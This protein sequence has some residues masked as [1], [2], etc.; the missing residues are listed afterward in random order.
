MEQVAARKTPSAASVRRKLHGWELLHLREH[1]ADL[2]RRL[3]ELEAENERLRKE[4]SYAEDVAES[5]RND[6]MRM[7]EDGME[8]GLTQDGHVVALAPSHPKAAEAAAL[9]AE[10]PQAR[11]DMNFMPHRPELLGELRPEYRIEHGAWIEASPCGE[12][13]LDA[14][15]NVARGSSKAIVSDSG[16]I[17]VLGHVM[18]AGLW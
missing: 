17:L 15:D 14:P 4:L 12:P 13:T 6:V 5:W 7:M 9:A 2:E 3:E 18:R 1:A 11:R 16:T 8:V 10:E